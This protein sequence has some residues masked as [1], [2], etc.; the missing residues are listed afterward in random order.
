M[1]W[2]A[3]GY[4][5]HE[6]GGRDGGNSPNGTREKTLF[7]AGPAPIAVPS[8]PRRQIQHAAGQEAAAATHS[9]C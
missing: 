9:C 6:A 3:I 1:R 8:R 7:E 5:K 4:G 2:M